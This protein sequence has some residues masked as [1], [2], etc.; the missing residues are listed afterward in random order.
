V[1]TADTL[2]LAAAGQE[3]ASPGGGATALALLAALIV[4]VLLYR[5][6]RGAWDVVGPL[7]RPVL[8]LAGALLTVIIVIMVLLGGL[9]RHAEAAAPPRPVTSGAPAHQTVPV[10][11]AV[12]WR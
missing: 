8:R 1:N 6:L 9:A 11:G 12:T 2:L 3:A 10:Q 4:A 7:V 5:L